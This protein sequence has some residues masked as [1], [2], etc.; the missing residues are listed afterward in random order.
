MW[1]DPMLVVP[2][3]FFLKAAIALENNG[4]TFKSSLC[5]KFIFI[6]FI[7]LCVGGIC[8]LVCVCV[9]TRECPT[10]VHRHVCISHAYGGQIL[11]DLTAVHLY[12]LR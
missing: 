12:F 11:G 9:C 7:H 4:V 3:G 5:L 2:P 10:S 8:T 6:L 1:D